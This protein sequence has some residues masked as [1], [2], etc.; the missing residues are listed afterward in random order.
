AAGISNVNIVAGVMNTIEVV[1]T[2]AVG[3]TDS[4]ISGTATFAKDVTSVTSAA[5]EPATWL[6]MIGG[7]GMVGAVLRRRPT[8]G[9]VFA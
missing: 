9:A 4:T 1:G 3:A 5:P 8:T 2:T 7:I 6:L